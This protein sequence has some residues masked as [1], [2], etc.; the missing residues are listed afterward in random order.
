M[1]HKKTD[2]Q[3]GG[4][5][6]LPVGKCSPPRLWCPPMTDPVSPTKIGLQDRILE[7]AT[8][9][10]A[11]RGYGSTSIR[12]VVERVGCTKPALY[13]YFDSKEA[14]YLETIRRPLLEF[15]A[16]A[17]QALEHPGDVGTRLHDFIDNVMNHM[18][19]KPAANRLLLSLPARPEKGQP[20]TLQGAMEHDP[21]IPLRALVADAQQRGQLRAT[22]DP[23]DLASA[24][25]SLIHHHCLV[26]SFK[27]ERPPPDVA[28]RIVDLLL[29]GASP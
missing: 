1:G 19:S 8:E 17:Q 13:Y 10:F 23:D 16:L 2:G 12:E 27:D 3:S 14:L 15:T 28:R 6:Y 9:L 22:V 11:E 24:I 26:F 18:V 20:C 7:A 4:G 29:H 5:G 21:A 25:L